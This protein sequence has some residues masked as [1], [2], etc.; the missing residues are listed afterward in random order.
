MARMHTTTFGAALAALS[1]GAACTPAAT[2]QT[3]TSGGHGGTAGHGGAPGSTGSTST[4][5]TSSAVATG[6]G[7]SGGSGGAGMGGA[8]GGTLCD[9]AAP[10]GSLY[11]AQGL[12]YPDF[13]PESMCQYRGDVLLIVNTAAV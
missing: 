12:R 11:A 8:G 2:H 7:G 13:V 9:P 6:V 4:T 1:V 5:A 10:A 3:T